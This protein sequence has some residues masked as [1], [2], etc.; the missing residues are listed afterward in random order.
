M[1][2]AL[3]AEAGLSVGTY[4]S[5]HLAAPQRAASAATAS[6]SATTTSPSV[7]SDLAALE[8]L[9]GVDADATSSS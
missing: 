1:I 5:P 9:A 8:P 3:L 2:A 6:R 7:L 4:T